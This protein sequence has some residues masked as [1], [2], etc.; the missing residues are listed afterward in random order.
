MSKKNSRHY[1]PRHVKSDAAPAAKA[2]KRLP[3]AA[4]RYL[5]EENLRASVEATEESDVSLVT[6]FRSRGSAPSV[7]KAEPR[8]EKAAPAPAEQK[9][10]V[11]E[12]REAAAK[13]APL[14][15]PVKPAEKAEPSA[16]KAE[17]SAEKKAEPSAEKA[18]SSAEKKAG[19]SAAA[20]TQ[21][22]KAAPEVK[23][24]SAP[25]KKAKN[26]R[27][28]TKAAGVKAADKQ[29]KDTITLTVLPA[30]EAT[31]EELAGY[32]Y[33]ATKTD[34]G[35]QP[36]K[37]KRRW[38]RV[39][40]IVVSVLLALVVAATGTIHVMKVRGRQSLL[41][42]SNS[43]VKVELPTVDESGNEISP[44]DQD[45]R[46]IKYNG[47]TYIYDTDIIRL[48]FI[49]VDK[50]HNT[51]KQQKMADAIYVIAINTKTGK[52]KVLNISRDIM[53]DVDTYSVGG[54]FDGTEEK[55]IAYSYA[56]YGKNMTGGEN[57]NK[58]ISRLLFGLPMND[59]FVLDLEGLT[60]LNDAVGGVTVTSV[61]TFESLET[62]EMI[63]EGEKVTLHGKDAEYYARLRDIKEL[64]SNND[65]MKRQQDYIMAFL[66][67]IMPAI[68]SNPT[69]IPDLYNAI[70][71]NSSTSLS[72][73]ELVYLVTD[74]ATK[75]KRI[76][77]VEFYK[78]N[79]TITL[80]QYAEMRVTNEEVLKTMLEIFYKRVE[81]TAATDAVGN[82]I[83]TAHPTVRPT[84]AV[85][86][87]PPTETP[88]VPP[89][90]AAE[91]TEAT[92]ASEPGNSEE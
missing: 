30:E 92:A 32:T 73:S 72:A 21:A 65:R 81:N 39:L 62:G 70:K 41:S 53:T 6:D 50:G 28:G 13:A 14:P 12:K 75:L 57:T 54:L 60:T 67:S 2:E 89:T 79:G 58:S 68:K 77:D 27:K 91:A 56:S 35:D 26:T 33:A 47:E 16:E 3:A 87:A 76:S 83:N 22:V 1:Q 9:A 69:I 78:F 63:H 43:N 74:V 38:L 86:T 66:G 51:D 24:E 85:E 23:S 52:I 82:P 59:Y 49:G 45:G 44:G 29:D 15:A 64:E 40:I 25:A 8:I 17:S 4:E 31:P 5:K 34:D 42:K 90:K 80:G 37:K 36:R 46:I 55:Q 84:Q 20:D 18:G 48:T 11:P 7:Q 61:L 71:E 88:S 10:A 19:S